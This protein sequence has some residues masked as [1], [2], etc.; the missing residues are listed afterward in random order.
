METVY[1]FN[2]HERQTT[3]FCYPYSGFLFRYTLS[4]CTK[5]VISHLLNVDLEQNKDFMETCFQG[6]ETKKGE[7]LADIGNVSVTEKRE[8]ES[9]SP[10]MKKLPE[11]KSQ[12]DLTLG[13]F[14][15]E[16]TDGKYLRCIPKL[17]HTGRKQTKYYCKVCHVNMCDQCFELFHVPPER[18]DDHLKNLHY[19]SLKKVESE[20]E[21]EIKKKK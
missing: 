3:V 16:N 19:K 21:L 15:R 2:A 12:Y 9:E 17:A 1:S 13:H 4:K 11:D 20:E 10:K 7:P 18:W 5:E 14:L 6:S 8:S